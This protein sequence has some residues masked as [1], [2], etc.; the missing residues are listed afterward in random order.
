MK[1][2][3]KKTPNEAAQEIVDAWTEAG[4]EDGNNDSMGSYT[5]M[6]CDGEAPQQDADDL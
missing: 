2:K 1:E 4:C 6:T 3:E 5:G